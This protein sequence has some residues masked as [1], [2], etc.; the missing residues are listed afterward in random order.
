MNS[1]ILTDGESSFVSGKSLSLNI[2]IYELRIEMKN[3]IVNV[4]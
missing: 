2:E 1:S 4:M 3:K